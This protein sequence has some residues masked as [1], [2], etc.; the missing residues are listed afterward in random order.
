MTVSRT[1]G[2]HSQ[3][4]LSISGSR[5]ESIFFPSS[6]SDRSMRILSSAGSGPLDCPDSPSLELQWHCPV[7]DQESEEL[8]MAHDDGAIASPVLVPLS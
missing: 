2:T 1:S 6:Y 5:E 8:Q 3:S 7:L 4:V